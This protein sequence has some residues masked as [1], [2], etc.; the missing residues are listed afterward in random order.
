M[1]IGEE[2]SGEE[3]CKVTARQVRREEKAG[4]EEEKYGKE[5]LI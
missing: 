5:E 4:E 2:W 3:E 1:G